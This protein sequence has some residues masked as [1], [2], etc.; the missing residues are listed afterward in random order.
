MSQAAG[1]SRGSRPP[2]ASR[3]RPESTNPRSLWLLPASWEGRLQCPADRALGSLSG[4]VPRRDDGRDGVTERQRT[5]CDLPWESRHRPRCFR[6]TLLH[7]MTSRPRRDVSRIGLHDGI[8]CPYK[9]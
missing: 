1:T 2:L 7:G 4:R 3:A 5:F 8:P 6:G 9:Q